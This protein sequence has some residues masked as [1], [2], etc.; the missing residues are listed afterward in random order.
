MRRHLIIAAAVTLCT[1]TASAQQR[2]GPPPRDNAAAA[3][4]GTAR[5]RGTVVGADTSSPLRR[6]Q[7]TL[8]S[9]ELGVRRATTTDAEGRYE[10]VELPAGRYVVGAGKGGYV[11]LQYG[12]RRP[13][14]AGRPVA[15]VDDQVIGDVDFVLPRGSVVTGRNVD[16]FGEPVTGAQIQVQRYQYGPGGQRRLTFAGGFGFTQSDD[17]GEF[18]VF[19]LMPGDY[20][21][22]AIMRN[23]VMSVGNPNPNDA[24]DG[25]L[26]TYYPGTANPAEAENVSVGVGQELSLQFALLPSR[27]ARI[28]GTVVDSQGRPV[29]TGFVSLRSVAD[30]GMIMSATAGQLGADGGFVLSNVA[31][32]THY[33]DVRPA[34]RGSGA[35][36]EFASVPVTVGSD[37]VRGLRITTGPGAM[38]SGRVIFE[39]TAARTGGVTAL[40]VTA[41]QSDGRPIFT[42]GGDPAASGLVADDG[43]FRLGG[44]TGQVLFR[45]IVPPAWTLKSVTLD[46][47]DI[48]DTPM[49]ASGDIADLR[50]VLTDRLTDVS[51]SVKDTRGRPIADYVVVV[52]PDEAKEGMA[53]ARYTR[54]VR[55]DQSGVFRARGLPPGRYAAIAVEAM[56]G[57][58]EWDPQF[59][60]RVRSGGRAF[61]LTEGQAVAL[62]LE[63]TQ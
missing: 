11:T 37:D 33:V 56:E 60:A 2:P 57:G 59:Q 35:Q 39:G 6:A 62:D 32:G 28:T 24:S 31:P 58:G 12:Q 18:R 44:A 1:L 50:I 14:E 51:G 27:M 40:R 61:S 25:F 26:P 38:I 63:L 29:T 17:R 20:V 34:P 15:V 22:S 52:V 19:G 42:M 41:Q 7:V 30:N 49:D 47:E 55:P 13:L 36:V 5:I 21:I 4:R 46:G 43:T 45:A 3:A 54:T 10:F 16:E 23:M 53:A 48:T 8:T 9:Q